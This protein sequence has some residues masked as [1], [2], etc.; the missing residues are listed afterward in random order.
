[1]YGIGLDQ[2][3]SEGDV[4]IPNLKTETDWNNDY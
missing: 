2:C 4:T 3:S 1:M